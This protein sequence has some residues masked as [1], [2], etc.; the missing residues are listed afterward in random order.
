MCRRSAPTATIE[1][2]VSTGRS[3]LPSVIAQA[4]RGAQTRDTRA[5]PA[6]SP[7]Q[8]RW[9]RHGQGKARRSAATPVR[10]RR[11]RSGQAAARRRR[12]DPDVRPRG[13]RDL[14]R[15][16][17]SCRTVQVPLPVPVLNRVR[18]GSSGVRRALFL[19]EGVV[20][21]TVLPG[22]TPASMSARFGSTG[23]LL[24]PAAVPIHVF[25][26]SAWFERGRLRCRS[27]STI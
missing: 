23:R 10:A 17:L 16:S 22:W 13:R 12:F 8:P 19:F 20:R 25:A 4:Q 27:A 2:T 11:R 15:R 7:A 3:L 9:R 26:E 6:R 21:R 24:T 5:D 14:L 1:T 18:G